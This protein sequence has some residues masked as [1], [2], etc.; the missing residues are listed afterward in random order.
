MIFPDGNYPVQIR[1]ATNAGEWSAWTDINYVTI[2]NTPLNREVDLTAEK[3]G[4]NIQLKWT[5]SITPAD[6]SAP[7]NFTIFRGDKLIAVTTHRQDFAFVDRFSAGDVEYHVLALKDD[8]YVSSNTVTFTLTLPADL[9]S[10]DGGLTYRALKYTP[11]RKSQDVEKS[12]AETLVYYAGRDRPVAISSGH[13]SRVRNCVYIFKSR[14][15]ADK[16]AEME[17]TPVLLKTTR[18]YIIYGIMQE[19]VQTDARYPVLTFKIREI[20]R[21]G[22]Y[23]EYSV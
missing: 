7:D 16:V 11:T 6:T 4:G 20:D 3:F 8:N 15:E 10:S 14:A 17:G 2:K 1:V 5:I 12:T 22:D 23:V 9:I 19:L 13:K 21:E 18:G